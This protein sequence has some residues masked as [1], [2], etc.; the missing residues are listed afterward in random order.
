MCWV[1]NLAHTP[2]ILL[3]NTT[4]GKKA[5][6]HFS[7]ALFP[8]GCIVLFWGIQKCDKFQKNNLYHVLEFRTHT[9][10]IT[11]FFKKIK[12]EKFLSSDKIYLSVLG[13]QVGGTL[14]NKI[15]IVFSFQENAD[16]EGGSFWYSIFIK[17]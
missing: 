5:L 16:F 17:L 2:C 7:G 10:W 14:L 9:Q 6:F 13:H 1:V 12:I 8:S 3:Y 11:N 15:V 4:C